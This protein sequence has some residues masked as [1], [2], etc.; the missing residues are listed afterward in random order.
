MKT[1]KLLTEAFG[2]QLIPW[3]LTHKRYMPWREDPTPYH[4][5]VS[6][7]MLQQ[8]RVDTVMPYYNHFIEALPNLGALAVVSEEEL[9]KLWE[10]L[11]YYSRVRNMQK[12]AKICVENYG[13][14]LPDNFLELL[15]LPGI[16]T[17]TAGAISSIAFLKPE[18][19][20]DGNVLRVISRYLGSYENISDP[21][22]KKKME[23]DLRTYLRT[24]SFQP[25]H[26]NQGMMELGALICVPN[27]AP[28]CEQ[29]PLAKDCVAFQNKLI[30]ELPVQNEKTARKI[31]EKTVVFGI[32][33]HQLLL[34]KRSKSGLLSGLYGF[35]MVEGFFNNGPLDERLA[36][37]G[38]QIDLQ[39]KY[40]ML[41]RKKHIFTHIEWHMDAVICSL[42]E[43]PSDASFVMASKEE[44]SHYPLPTAFKKWN[45]D[46]LLKDYV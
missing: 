40:V 19:V 7:I 33:Q 11:G 23:E 9:L 12:A 24:Y 37:K 15:K 35:P 10:G 34:E 28:K 13:G 3:F 2:N 25:S 21:K 31:E 4:V 27:G 38:L 41:P 44:M 42:K 8:T 26:F 17:Y 30:D 1:C 39:K 43:L 36:S 29:C 5:W 18:P 14:E 6:E 46:Q 45:L 20:V 32:Y 22:T 16:G